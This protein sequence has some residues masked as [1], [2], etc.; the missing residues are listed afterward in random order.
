MAAT[1]GYMISTTLSLPS[2][3]GMSEGVT[4]GPGKKNRILRLALT[5]S[6]PE[7]PPGPDPASI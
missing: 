7:Y 4:R 2:S 5:S 3:L 1:R 6:N